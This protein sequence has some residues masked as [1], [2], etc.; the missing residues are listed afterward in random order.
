MILRLHLAFIYSLIAIVAIGQV[1]KI[2]TATGIFTFQQFTRNIIQLTYQP[3]GYLTNENVSDAVILKPLQFKSS[4]QIAVAPFQQSV[5]FS[6][7]SADYKEGKLLFG[8]NKSIVLEDVFQKG[9]FNGFR[10]KLQSGEQI[11][12]GGKGLSPSIA[13]DINFLCTIIPR[14]DIAKEQMH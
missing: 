5:I 6:S 11:F 4:K 9:E 12:G 2:K 13:G 8:R 3:K 7:T 10:F 1:E 14:M